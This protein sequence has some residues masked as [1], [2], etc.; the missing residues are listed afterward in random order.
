[1]GFN[2][3]A[4]IINDSLNSMAED[5]ELG[6]RLADGVLALSL[7]KPVDVRAGNHVNAIYLVESHHADHMVP[8][9]VGG[10]YGVEVTG[11]L[12]RRDDKDMEMDLLLRLAHKKGYTLRKKPEKK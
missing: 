3:S 7:G 2:T 5:K 1:M 9:L 11:A 12:V 10:N 4:V 6:K 8:I